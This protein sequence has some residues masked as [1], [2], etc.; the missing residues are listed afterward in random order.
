MY[1]KGYRHFIYPVYHFLNNDG[2]MPCIREMRQNQWK[3]TKELEQLQEE[4]LAILLKHA[5]SNI[6]YYNRLFK[7]HGLA[8]SDLLAGFYGYIRNSQRMIF[9]SS[10]VL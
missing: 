5:Y 10:L 1:S 2:V 6:P 8:E 4:K 7:Q 9:S 3:S